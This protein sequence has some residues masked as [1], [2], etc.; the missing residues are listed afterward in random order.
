MQLEGDAIQINHKF[1]FGLIRD[2][3]QDFRKHLEKQVEHLHTSTQASPD[4]SVPTSLLEQSLNFV[5]VIKK[6]SN[7]NN[8]EVG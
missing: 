1:T 3:Q 4:K 5:V 2:L 7:L 8:Q 6:I